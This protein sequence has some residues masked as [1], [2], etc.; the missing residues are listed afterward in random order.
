[1]V[2]KKIAV[3]SG[4]GIGP[5]IM[6]EAIKV[7]QTI[8]DTYNHEFN[9]IT[10][11]FGAF[12]WKSE[13]TVFPNKTKE[14][15][16]SADSILKGPIGDPSIT[17]LIT[18]PDETPEIGALLALRKRYETFA[19]YRPVILP[20]Q[21]NSFSPLK[22]QIIKNG[23]NIMMIRELVGGIYFGKKVEK[24]KNKNG[25]MYASDICMYT[26]L[27]IKRIARVAF[28]E[29]RKRKT[30][31]TNIHKGNVLATSRFWNGVV[32]QIQK[33]EFPDIQLK[34]CLVDAAA[35]Y[36]VTNPSSFNGV[37]LLENMQGDILS[38]MAG[39]IIGSLGFMPSACINA[40]TQKGFYEPAHGSAPD[41]A[42]KDT[43]NPYAQIGS[44]AL[45]LDIA[46]NLNQESKCV[47]DAL[48]AVLLKGYRTPDIA[49]NVTPKNKIIGTSKFGDL[50]TAHIKNQRGGKN[51]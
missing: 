48:H 30:I 16:D 7:L 28:S 14:I 47:W 23:I 37:M 31:V 10:A 18:N 38:D 27:Q 50:V 3:L 33:E 51:E 32:E 22:K 43:A 1:M 42:G 44:V 9:C 24:R 29:A 39:G 4:D 35:F 36:L 20:N 5:E 40:Q 41:I 25:E 49:D 45:M 46:F 13:G 15:C 8:G 34:H 26:E 6:N 19:N 17:T 2:E 11:P 12:A 21:M